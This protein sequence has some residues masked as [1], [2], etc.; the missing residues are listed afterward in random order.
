MFESF[1]VNFNVKDTNN[2]EYKGNFVN[3]IIFFA[4]NKFYKYNIQYDNFIKYN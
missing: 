1:I 3:L 2:I 4:I